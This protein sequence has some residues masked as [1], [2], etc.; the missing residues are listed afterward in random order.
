MYIYLFVF[1]INLFVM[2]ILVKGRY[3]ENKL[4]GSTGI[5]GEMGGDGERGLDGLRGPDGNRGTQGRIGPKGPQGDMI[6]CDED[7]IRNKVSKCLDPLQTW[8]D[9]AF[10]NW[11]LRNKGC[12]FGYK[13]TSD[14][15]MCGPKAPYN[16]DDYNTKCRYNFNGLKGYGEIGFNDWRNDLWEVGCPG[17]PGPKITNNVAYPSGSYAQGIMNKRFTSSAIPG[18]ADITKDKLSDCAKR[19]LK[20]PSCAGFTYNK[21]TKMCSVKNS[22]T[23]D[24]IVNDNNHISGYKIITADKLP[25]HKTSCNGW[26]CDTLHDTCHGTAKNPG[27]ICLNRSNTPQSCTASSS[28]NTYPKLTSKFASSG[29]GGHYGHSNSVERGKQ[30]CNSDPNCGGFTHFEGAGY[31]QLFTKGTTLLDKT[32]GWGS[33]YSSYK[34]N[35]SNNYCWHNASQNSDITNPLGEN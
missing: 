8:G 22:A 33:P 1:L 27:F 17:I 10:T 28:I 9:M 13:K 21:D 25:T 35:T 7:F 14:G 30:K 19:C 6:V 26:S 31:I 24:N 34:K 3:T 23:Q 4:R 2:Y 5:Q 16:T 12:L 29:Y 20:I 11:S 32:S 18:Y 15:R